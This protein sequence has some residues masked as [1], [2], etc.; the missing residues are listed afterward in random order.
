MSSAMPSAPIEAIV[1]TFVPSKFARLIA[2]VNVTPSDQYTFEFVRSSSSTGMPR[3]TAPT[4]PASHLPPPRPPPSPAP[5][6]PP[7][8][9]PAFGGTPGSGGGA[10]RKKYLGWPWGGRPLGIPVL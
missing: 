6:A 9:G 2:L 8:R 5:P 3:R 7:R 4:A 1:S 10:G